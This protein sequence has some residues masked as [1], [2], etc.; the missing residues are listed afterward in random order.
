M[1]QAT[2]INGKYPTIY[3]YE[4]STNLNGMALID[5]I[6]GT[7][8]LVLDS[9]VIPTNS[10]FRHEFKR[11]IEKKNNARTAAFDEGYVASGGDRKMMVSNGTMRITDA[12]E[13]DILT[14]RNASDNGLARRAENI[15]N[16]GQSLILKKADSILYGGQAHPDGNFDAK[17]IPGFASYLD[18][19]SDYDAMVTRWEDGECPFDSENCL[20]LDN[21][22]GADTSDSATVESA[23]ENKVWTSI[24]GFAFGTEGAYT[25]YPSNLAMLA[26]YN[27]EYHP[28]NT[29]TYTDKRDGL[30]KYRFFDLV[31]GETCFG[32]GVA[33]RFCLTGLRNIYLGHKTKEDKYDE[34]YRVE[35]N[36]ITLADF[37][38]LGKTGLSM[39]FYGSRYLVQQMAQYQ[40]NRIVRVDMGANTNKGNIGDV[41]PN[42]ILVAPGIVLKG[43]YAIKRNESFIA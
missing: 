37:F 25:T 3:D 2:L 23:Q 41:I 11:V 29:S 9:C 12:K 4:D 21:Q 27:I 30:T 35:Q 43:D 16:L 38:S 19:I 39:V 7:S 13:F 6:K 1:D 31:T 24:Y 36:L 40:Q 20:A 10:G 42:E 14:E 33:N 32:V 15:A 8:D 17:E 34:M 28:D 26:G 5:E 22:V 18:K